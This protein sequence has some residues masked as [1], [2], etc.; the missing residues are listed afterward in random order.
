MTAGMKKSARAVAFGK[1]FASSRRSRLRS[2]AG[3]KSVK[4]KNLNAFSAAHNSWEKEEGS[5]RRPHVL[6]HADDQDWHGKVAESA[7]SPASGTKSD[8]WLRRARAPLVRANATLIVNSVRHAIESNWQQVTDAR[9]NKKKNR[10]KPLV[11]VAVDAGSTNSLAET[12]FQEEMEEDR[13]KTVGNELSKLVAFERQVPLVVTKLLTVVDR[14]DSTC[15]AKRKADN[16]HLLHDRNSFHLAL[17]QLIDEHL[18]QTLGPQ[19]GVALRVVVC[20]DGSWDLSQATDLV[21]ATYGEARDAVASRVPGCS[22]GCGNGHK[23]VVNV[24]GKCYSSEEVEFEEEEE[25]E[26]E[27]EQ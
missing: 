1:K 24:C 3:A 26:E 11:V 18:E 6:T 15:L 2:L 27:Q 13:E 5:A 21:S 7:T 20:H 14:P 19:L 25:E 16:A 12:A 9:V 23:V 4:T 8:E 22:S 10:K 17:L